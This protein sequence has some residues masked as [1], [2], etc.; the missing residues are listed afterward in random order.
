MEK[1]DG[2]VNGDPC[3]IDLKL[4]GIKQDKDSFSGIGKGFR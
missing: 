4:I 3:L 2:E 1:E